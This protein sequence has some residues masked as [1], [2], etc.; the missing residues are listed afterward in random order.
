MESAEIIGKD[1]G[2]SQTQVRRYIR[3]TNLVPELLDMVDNLT[4][5]QQKK[6]T[7]EDGKYSITYDIRRIRNDK[8]RRPVRPPELD[9]LRDRAE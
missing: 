3:L 9:L 4:A 2:D 6:R 5:K 8:E 7:V 1:S